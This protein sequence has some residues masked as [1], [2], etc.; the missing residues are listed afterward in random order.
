M[1]TDAFF[2]SKS[3][4][5]LEKEEE[6]ERKDEANKVGKCEIYDSCIIVSGVSVSLSGIDGRDGKDGEE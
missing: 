2:L 6:T 3:K 1:A 4:M 5:K